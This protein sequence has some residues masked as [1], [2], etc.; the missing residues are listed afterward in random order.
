MCAFYILELTSPQSDVDVDHNHYRQKEPAHAQGSRKKRKRQLHIS[1]HNGDH[2]NSVRRIGDVSGQNAELA[3]NKPADIY[4]DVCVTVIL[5]LLFRNSLV[6]GKTWH[7]T[8]LFCIN[9]T[10]HCFRH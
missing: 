1:Y 2:Y 10:I 9:L 4:I 7:F 3:A 6:V 8:I 5:V